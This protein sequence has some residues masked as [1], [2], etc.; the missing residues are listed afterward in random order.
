MLVT[1]LELL[2]V[3]YQAQQGGQGIPKPV[4]SKQQRHNLDSHQSSHVKE[5]LPRL[6]CAK[7]EMF[8]C[9]GGASRDCGQAN[10]T[11]DE[12]RDD[13]ID[14]EEATTMTWMMTN[15]QKRVT[16]DYSTMSIAS[17]R[18]PAPQAHHG[19]PP[20]STRVAHGTHGVLARQFWFSLCC[21]SQGVHGTTNITDSRN[22]H[23]NKKLWPA[24]LLHVHEHSSS[25]LFLTVS[26]ARTVEK[27]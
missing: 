21:S 18:Q 19:S 3:H 12:K 4:K 16:S 26:N 7:T 8:I 23:M 20:H 11:N 15:L 9:S 14:D 2:P 6:L 25:A 13:E 10:E 5:T 1:D 17:R 24:V 27:G 22:R